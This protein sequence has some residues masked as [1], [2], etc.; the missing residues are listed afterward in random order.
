MPKRI[1]VIDDEYQITRVLKRSLGAHRYDVRTAADGE[2][3]LELFRDFDPDLVITDLSMPEMSGIDVCRAIR[4]HSRTPIIVLS[5]KGEE[6]T[7]VAALD[8]GADDYV[9]KPFGMD[10]LLARVRASLRRVPEESEPTAI[11]EVGDLK[12]DHS[13]R[14]VSV[15]GKDV[16]L[17]PKEFELMAYL[18]E[19]H[20]RVITHRKLLTKIWGGDY[21][22]QTE[23]LRVFIGNLRKKIEPAPSKPRYI[24]T[25][26]WVGYRCVP[27]P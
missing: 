4:K 5:V 11:V 27:A 25:E 8:A 18:I 13:R 21:T 20:D 26:P 17:T 19:N 16:H 7:K 14:I 22:E 15:M 23:Y 6:Q 1:L 12:L 10:E 3:G 9:T 2:S 24:V